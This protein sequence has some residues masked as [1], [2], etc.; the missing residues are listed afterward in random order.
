MVTGVCMAQPNKTFEDFQVWQS[1]RQSLLDTIVSH[2]IPVRISLVA[3]TGQLSPPIEGT[4]TRVRENTAHFCPCAATDV[5]TLDAALQGQALPVPCTVSCRIE[6]D[7]PFAMVLRPGEYSSTG[8]VMDLERDDDALP[9]L[10]A[11]Q[12]G[13]HL[14]MRPPRRYDRIV[15]RPAKDSLVRLLAARPAPEDRK[16]LEA[17]LREAMRLHDKS[18]DV[19]DIS[20]GGACILNYMAPAVTTPGF[21]AFYLLLFSPHKNEKGALPFVFLAKKAGSRR[22]GPEQQGL[23]L[24]FVKE[25][26]WQASTEGQL[27]WREIDHCGSEGL[28][29]LLQHSDSYAEETELEPMNGGSAQDPA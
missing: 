14:A 10:V 13:Q 25:L 21:G 17:L 29:L 19:V 20:A 12:L 8:T 23:R 27:V 11:L 2:Q 28:N 6:Y 26:D 1:T 16:E 3:K 4:F 15:W 18:D 9:L 22:N 5:D 24:H 7:S